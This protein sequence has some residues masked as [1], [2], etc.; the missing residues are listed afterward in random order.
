ME[1]LEGE[2]ARRSEEGGVP[3]V[4]R[5]KSPYYLLLDIQVYIFYVNIGR[6]VLFRSFYA[7]MKYILR[8]RIGFLAH[9][10]NT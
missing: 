9:C 1:L 10:K 2:E 5:E 6:H 3:D 4:S 7:H 8:K